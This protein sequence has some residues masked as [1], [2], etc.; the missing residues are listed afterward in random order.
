MNEGD[1]DATLPTRIALGAPCLASDGA[2][3]YR[4]RRDPPVALLDR[5]QDGLLRPHAAIIAGWTRCPVA[6]QALAPP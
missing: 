6:E 1:V 2:G 5:V 4:L 3:P